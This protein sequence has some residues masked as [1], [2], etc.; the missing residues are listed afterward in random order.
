MAGRDSMAD[1]RRGVHEM[2]RIPK[3]KAA[4]ETGM[5]GAAGRG[6]KNGKKYRAG[7]YARLS[8][9]NDTDKNES[10]DVQFG[11]VRNFVEEFNRKQDG[12]IEIA[13]YYSDLGKTGSNF[14]RDGF[15]HMMQDI[16]LGE[17]NCVI[18]KDLSR[19]GRNYLEAGNYIEKIFPFPGVRFIAVSD[20]FD[21]G[22]NGNSASQLAS[23]KKILSMICMRKIFLSRPK[24][25][26]S[27]NARQAHMWAGRRRMGIFHRGKGKYEGWCQ[28]KIQKR[29]SGIFIR[30]LWKIKIIQQWQMI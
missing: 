12:H 4:G 11:I 2:G 26:C 19:F 14:K 3:R 24:Y 8:S 25:A 23:E 7:V 13:D 17:I 27:R 16:R 28:M 30:C 22:E 15:L 18:V 6:K 5:P 21:T 20:G 29:L 9:D 1:I 10:I